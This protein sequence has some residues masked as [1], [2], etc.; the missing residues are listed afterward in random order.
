[1]CVHTK[2]KPFESDRC[3][4]VSLNLNCHKKLHSEDIEMHACVNCGKSF[5]QKVH[6]QSHMRRHTGEQPCQCNQRHQCVTKL[7]SVKNRE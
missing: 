4:S 5:A 6:L 1:M 7:G 3:F 2:E